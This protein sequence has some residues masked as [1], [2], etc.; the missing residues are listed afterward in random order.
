[1]AA[2]APGFVHPESS[3]W[4]FHWLRH[5]FVRCPAAVKRAPCEMCACVLDALRFATGLMV[6][7]LYDAHHA[8]TSGSNVVS[9]NMGNMTRAKARAI[10]ASTPAIDDD[11]TSVIRL[12]ETLERDFPGVV[13]P[14]LSQRRGCHVYAP[15]MGPGG[16]SLYHTLSSLYKEA[17]SA[18]DADADA[19]RR[20]SAISVVDFCLLCFHLNGQ[21]SLTAN[22]VSILW[23]GA[24]ETNTVSTLF[25]RGGARDHRALLSLYE[26]LL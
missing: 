14:G 25:G 11:A 26:S 24:L 5:R 13:V 1:M 15:L 7:A 12:M 3:M 21:Y 16:N 17:V 20:P 2:A 10:V 22:A 18:A 4:F 8:F 9:I 19:R 23:S 6:E